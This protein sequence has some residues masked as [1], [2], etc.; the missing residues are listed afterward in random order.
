MKKRS[1]LNNMEF[2]PKVSFLVIFYSFFDL[3]RAV[4]VELT[5]ISASVTLIVTPKTSR[6]DTYTE[7]EWNK[8]KNGVVRYTQSRI[9]F[10]DISLVCFLFFFFFASF[11][12]GLVT[13]Y[14]SPVFAHAI[15]YWNY[16]FSLFVVTRC[17]WYW[18][19]FEKFE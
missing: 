11:Q 6:R 14:P 16:R 13:K 4:C 10:F 12:M 3:T 5:E 18:W 2:V 15:H 7:S 8:N 1:W 9:G 17:R 19:S